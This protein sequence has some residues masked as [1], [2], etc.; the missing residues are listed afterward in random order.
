MS[1]PVSDLQDFKDK[2]VPFV[3]IVIFYKI[4]VLCSDTLL[5]LAARIQPC[6]WPN[7][8]EGGRWLWTESDR[9]R[10]GDNPPHQG[11]KDPAKGRHC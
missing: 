3:K 6:Q 10:K 1:F 4:R 8:R 7:Q 9:S 2:P 11:Q 5:S